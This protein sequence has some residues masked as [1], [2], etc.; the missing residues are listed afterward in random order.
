MEVGLLV[1]NDTTAEDSAPPMSKELLDS[2]T[3]RVGGLVQKEFPITVVKIL[4]TNAVEPNSDAKQFVQLANSHGVDYMVLAIF[5]SAEVEYPTFFAFGPTQPSEG[6]GT[7]GRGSQLGFRAE[8]YA[9]V[10][11]AVLDPNHDQVIVQADG[12]DWASLD[13]LNV[14]VESNNFP[15]IRRSRRV[16]PIFP[17]EENAHDALRGVSGSEAL[18]QALMHLKEAWNEKFATAG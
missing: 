8:N 2:L 16:S 10:E 7:P 9:L 14:P 13:R 17:T 11:M 12:R 1:L 5:S 18:D 3:D 15:V 4:E 6:G